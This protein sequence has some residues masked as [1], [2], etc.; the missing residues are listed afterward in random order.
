MEAKYLPDFTVY[1]R[2]TVI[3]TAW[4]WQIYRHMGQ[5]NRIER[6]EVNPHSYGQLKFDKG[7]NNIQW[8]KDSLFNKW[9]WESQSHAN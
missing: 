3:K 5:Q 7:D 1:Y 2:A 6:P 4:Y 8:E 9:Y